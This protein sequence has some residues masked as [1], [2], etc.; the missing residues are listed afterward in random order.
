MCHRLDA[1]RVH[2]T[3][4]LYEAQNFRK[5]IHVDGQLSVGD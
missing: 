4:L 3:E 1:V 2:C 5:A